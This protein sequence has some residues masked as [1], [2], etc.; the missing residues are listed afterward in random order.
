MTLTYKTTTVAQTFHFTS[1]KP[2]GGWALFTVDGAA[3]TFQ[4][5]SDWGDWHYRWNTEALEYPELHPNFRLLPFLGAG[6]HDYVARKLMPGSRQT[7]LD[8]AASCA[9]IHEFLVSLVVK[10]LP[11]LEA[12]TK[13]MVG[14]CPT[15][16]ELV[17][18][19][20]ELVQEDDSLDLE[21][22]GLAD[23]HEYLCTRPSREFLQ[24]RD[25]LLPVFTAHLRQ[26]GHNPG[27]GSLG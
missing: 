5:M 10:D 16:E 14:G 6:D 8:V 22:I 7:E 20:D 17:A 4:I 9:G 3:G 19:V 2:L 23:I 21:E 12:F 11:D 26:L 15:A 25:E 13:E 1:G 27:P 24:L 18:R